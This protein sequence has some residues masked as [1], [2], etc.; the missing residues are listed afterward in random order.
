MLPQAGSP[1]IDAGSNALIPTGISTDQRG[2]AR[3]FNG[4]VDIGAV[5]LGASLAPALS[6]TAVQQSAPATARRRPRRG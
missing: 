5:E 3:I 4:T 1:V 2:Y 6:S